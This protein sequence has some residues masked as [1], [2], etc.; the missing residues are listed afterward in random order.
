MI[1]RGPFQPRTFC[2]LI[3][4][5]VFCTPD[6]NVCNNFWGDEAQMSMNDA[7]LGIQI[8]DLPVFKVFEYAGQNN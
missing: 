2:D 8:P 6:R 7:L 3:F 5:Q 1:P 4:Q